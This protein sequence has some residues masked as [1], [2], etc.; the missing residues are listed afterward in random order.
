VSLP[1]LLLASLLALFSQP[2]ITLDYEGG[3]ASPRETVAP[4]LAVYADGRVVA[5]MPHLPVPARETR[6]SRAA[7]RRLVLELRPKTRSPKLPAGFRLL[8]EDAPIVRIRVGARTAEQLALD[9]L[10]R[11]LPDQEDVQRLQAAHRRLDAL[12]KA[13]MAGGEEEARA[14]VERANRELK[15]RWPEAEPFGIRDMSVGRRWITL[16]RSEG[17]RWIAVTFRDG[18]LSV[19]RGG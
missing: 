6:L 18:D 8:V 2:V 7:V 5:R 17:R 3:D 1:L 12:W 14:L 15:R 9:L 10:A 13:T 4:W 11:Q 19:E 16:R